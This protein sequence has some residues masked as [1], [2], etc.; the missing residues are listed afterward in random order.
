MNANTSPPAKP[1]DDWPE[2]TDIY[3]YGIVEVYPGLTAR[4]TRVVKIYERF[5]SLRIDAPTLTQISVLLTVGSPSGVLYDVNLLMSKGY[6]ELQPDPIADNKKARKTCR[7]RLT[8]R[9]VN[10]L[11]FRGSK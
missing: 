11:V 4:Q 6:L 9:A 2:S 1:Q 10:Q 3:A 5:H 7:Y 8:S